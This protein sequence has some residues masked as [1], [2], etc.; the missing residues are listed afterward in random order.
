MN[1]TETLWRDL[2][3]EQPIAGDRIVMLGNRYSAL[4]AKEVWQR[5]VPS[6]N[7]ISLDE[8]EPTA[9]DADSNGRIVVVSKGVGFPWIASWQ[10]FSSSAT[11]F[12]PLP[13]F[14]AP[15]PDEAAFEK[16]W[17]DQLI[18]NT[19]T[20]NSKKPYLRTAWQAAIAYVRTERKQP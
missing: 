13:K 9:E 1:Q 18:A 6:P 14:V 16:W 8:R 10:E 7:W 15:D 3:K 17:Q 11:H 12:F 2:D 5:P 20:T 19:E 4:F